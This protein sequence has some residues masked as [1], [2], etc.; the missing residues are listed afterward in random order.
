MFELASVDDYVA[1]VL[2][3]AQR[4]SAPPV[5]VGHSM[6]AI[7]VQRAARRR[8]A[9]AIVLLAPVPPHGLS[10]SLFTLATRDPPLFLALNTMQL[11][12]GGDAQSRAA[13]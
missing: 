3:A 6:G 12:N 1:D 7:V 11:A 13:C 10:G 2:E 9:R 8:G 4:L 5:L